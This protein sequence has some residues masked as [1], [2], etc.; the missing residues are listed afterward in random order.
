VV[1]LATPSWEPAQAREQIQAIVAS[2][3]DGIKGKV[4]IDVINGLN[5]F[6][7]LSLR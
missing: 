5:P 2:L 7:S 1:L 6:P 4:L 3:G